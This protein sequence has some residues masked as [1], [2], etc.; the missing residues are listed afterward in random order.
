MAIEVLG[1]QIA[2]LLAEQLH[3][4]LRYRCLLLHCAD[5]PTLVAGVRIGDRRSQETGE[6]LRAGVHRSI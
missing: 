5:M 6:P 4:R 2:S 1:D 3:P